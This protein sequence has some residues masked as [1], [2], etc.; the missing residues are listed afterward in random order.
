MA[1][2]FIA[3]KHACYASEREVRLVV[4]QEHVERFG[5]LQHRVARHRLL[6]Y[7]STAPLYADA[8]CQSAQP[9]LPLCEVRVGPVADQ[10]LMIR[11]I[12]SYLKRKG[13]PSVE[14]IPSAIPY[15]G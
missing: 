9:Q 15:R 14:V 6:P 13:Y 5:G 3:F 8:S 4:A 10:A 7:L 12:Q 1:M 11:S 2:E